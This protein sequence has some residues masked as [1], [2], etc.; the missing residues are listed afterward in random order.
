MLVRA[1]AGRPEFVA[2]VGCWAGV[3]VV[4]PMGWGGAMVRWVVDGVEVVGSGGAGILRVDCVV[5]IVVAGTRVVLTVYGNAGN[6]ML[7]LRC[8]VVPRRP[9]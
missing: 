4:C 5:H 3:D 7:V 1:R 9:N 8:K 2:R 6:V